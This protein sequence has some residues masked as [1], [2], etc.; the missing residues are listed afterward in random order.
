M[1][2][3]SWLLDELASV[4]EEHLNPAYVREYDRKSGFDPDP[5]LALLD[6]YGFTAESTL[7]DFGCGTGEFALAAARTC[8]RVVAVDI[9][10][11][12]LDAL[13]RKAEQ[14]GMKNLE[15]VGQGF[16][17][18]EQR[19]EKADFVFSRNALHHLPDFWKALALER[20]A[21]LLKPGGVLRLRDLVFSFEPHD[22]GPVIEAW[23]QTAPARPEDGW[24]RAELETHLRQEFSTFSW[25]LEPMLKRAG[26]EIREAA[27]SESKVFAAYVCVR[28]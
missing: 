13:R 27:Y 9:S 1:E 3:R 19:G 22:S 4:G 25:L 21:R 26:F 18:Y 11:P 28:I 2:R 20:I 16:L 6:R 8:R 10:T 17:T 23:L 15:I 7:I 14:E 5:D 24:T 12:M